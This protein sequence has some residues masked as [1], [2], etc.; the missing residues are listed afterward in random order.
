MTTIS[1]PKTTVNK[2]SSQTPAGVEGQKI[3]VIGQKTSSGSATPK[4]LNQDVKK[5][6]IAGLFGAKSLLAGQ[7]RPMFKIFEDSQGDV[8]PIV[9]VI[10][11]EDAVAGTQ[12]SA[13]ITMS[14][15]GA[16]GD[17]TETGTLVF[18]VAGTDYSIDIVEGEAIADV[19][20]KLE[21]AL[22]DAEAQFSVA[23]ST[24]VN[25][26]TFENKGTVGNGVDMS[27]TGLSFDGTDYVLGNIKVVITAFSG[28]STDPDV[29][30]VLDVVSEVRYQTISAP[31]E[32][33]TDYLL[34]DYLDT[35]FNVTNNILDGVAVFCKNDTLANLKTALNAL[36]SQSCV[37]ICDKIYAE[38]T[39]KAG[40]LKQPTYVTASQFSAL[41]GLRR[42]DGANIIN[43]TPASTYGALDGQ[44]GVE[45]SSLP[46]ANTAVFDIDIL[47]TGRGFTSTEV[48]E[49]HDA[50]GTVIGNNIVN[51]TVLLGQAYTTY[52]TDVAGN[53]DVTWRFL[54]TVDTLSASA[55]YIQKNLRKR[56]AQSRLTSGTLTSGRNVTNESAIRAYALEL[57]KDLG[58]LMLVPTGKEAESYFVNNLTI[59]IDYVE[60]SVNMISNFAIVVQLRELIMNLITQFGN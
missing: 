17:A 24:L 11:L 33:G 8:A 56:F 50:G 15:T 21:T 58:E 18:R 37:Y 22:T 4:A 3:L 42:T 25:T 23:E 29:S 45:I 6:D 7:L 36:N 48:S 57:Y 60:G 40:S 13:T 41:R 16:T 27:V 39:Y 32:Y 30:D 5:N 54:N 28:G 1:F 9:D 35:R 44:G 52:K 19:S 2:L 47:D 10:A 34:D 12:A 43:I 31:V 38:D 46:Y 51:N 14:D 49:L 55:E 59:E 26:L 20:T 53:E